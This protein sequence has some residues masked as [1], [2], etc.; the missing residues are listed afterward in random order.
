MITG[1]VCRNYLDHMAFMGLILLVLFFVMI[2]GIEVSLLL[3]LGERRSWKEGG[4]RKEGGER[5]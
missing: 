1:T 3:M 4:P 2:T 5:V